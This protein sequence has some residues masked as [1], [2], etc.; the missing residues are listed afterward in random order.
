MKY[1]GISIA[2]ILTGLLVGFI[3][4]FSFL[5]RPAESQPLE[6]DTQT[7]PTAGPVVPPLADS[8]GLEQDLAERETL[9]QAQLSQL[10]QTLQTRQA[11]YQEQ[12]ALLTDQVGAAQAQLEALTTQKQTLT[13]QIAQLEAARTERLA[14]YQNQRTESRSQYD[15]RYAEIHRQLNEVL[16]KLA[17]AN[18][19]LSR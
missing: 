14:L 16:T 8:A 18:A 2:V 7:E 12:M 3:V 5:P 1:I 11:T 17:Q 9:Y 6:P 19:Q 4:I 13:E 10:E 15:A